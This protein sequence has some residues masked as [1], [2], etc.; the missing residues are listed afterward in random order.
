MQ[1]GLEAEVSKH[2]HLI[3]KYLSKYE[4]NLQFDVCRIPGIKYICDLLKK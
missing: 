4:A 2:K 1:G 3:N